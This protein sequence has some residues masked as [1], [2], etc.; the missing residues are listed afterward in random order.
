MQPRIARP[1]RSPPRCLPAR[2]RPRGTRTRWLR[3]A[4]VAIEPDK[5]RP[6][7]GGRM[8]TTTPSRVSQGWMGILLLSLCALSAAQAQ[9]LTGTRTSSFTYYGS[10]D[11]ALN[12]LLKSETV[13][14]DNAQLCVTTTY[15]YDSYG[16]KQ[17]ST[18]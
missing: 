1:I 5:S 3:P 11:G 13:E 6:D 10:S 4:A 8:K 17:K 14:P 16:N 12:G 18:T 7:E 9:T 2:A 15:E